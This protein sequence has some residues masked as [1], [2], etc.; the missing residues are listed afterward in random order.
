LSGYI[1]NNLLDELGF[2]AIPHPSYSPDLVPSD[3]HLFRSLQ[4]YLNKQNFI[5][6]EHLVKVLD[7]YFN[8][9]P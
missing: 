4:S 6:R 8:I 7:S 3:F 9:Q 2:K 5:D 1:N